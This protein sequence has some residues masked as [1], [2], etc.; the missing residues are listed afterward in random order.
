MPV[1][2]SF[3]VRVFFAT[4]LMWRWDSCPHT[5]AVLFWHVYRC[6]LDLFFDGEPSLEAHAT[7]TFPPPSIA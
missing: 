3:R 1:S 6:R 5:F 2:I 4:V 7:L